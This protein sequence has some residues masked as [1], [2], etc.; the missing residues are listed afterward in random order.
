M[1]PIKLFLIVNR[2]IYP[3]NGV[4]LLAEIKRRSPSTQVIMISGNL[5]DEIRD[6]CM[7]LGAIT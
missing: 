5:T 6:G 3:M 7:K 2:L 4:E 1:G